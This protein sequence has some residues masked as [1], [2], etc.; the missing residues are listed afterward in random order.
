[1][2]KSILFIILTAAVMMAAGCSNK[3]DEMPDFIPTPIPKNGGEVTDSENTTAGEEPGSEETPEDSGTEEAPGDDTQATPTPP[4]VHVGQTTV[5]YVKL[6]AYGA[7]L[8]VRS[9]PSKDSD[10]VGFLVHT[11]RIRVVDIADGWASFLY[12]DEVCYVS[13][14]YLVTERPEYLTP[15][16]HTPVPTVKPNQ[17][18]TLEGDSG[19]TPS[20]I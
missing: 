5:M 18:G 4:T 3:E 15:P 12:N 19:G 16:T 13:A 8:N 1:M 11:E 10:I 2:K 14:D 6:K 7:I 17:E 9:A 20:E